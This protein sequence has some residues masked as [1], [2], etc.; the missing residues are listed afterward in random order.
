MTTQRPRLLVIED[1]AAVRTVFAE[2]LPG[3]GYDL[4]LAET[5]EQGFARLSEQ[6]Y[7][8]VLSDIVL[9]GS[10]GLELL[11]RVRAGYPDL[12]VILMTAF[13]SMQS[14]LEAVSAGV[15]DYLVKPFDNLDEVLL[16]IRR[17]IDKRRLVLEN[18]RL[19]EHLREANASIAALNQD[20]EARVERRT[21]ELAAANAQLAE[22]SVTDDVTGLYNQ[23]FL[24]ERLAD[25][26]ARADRYGQPLSVVMLDLDHFKQVNDTRDHLFG[27]RV[28]ARV[29][30]VVRQEV[31][32]VDPVVRYGGDEFVIILPHSRLEQAVS[33][34]ERVR[35]AIAAAN[36]GDSGEVYRIT[37]SFGVAALGACEATDPLALLRAADKALYL[38]KA[39]GRD[40]VAVMSGDR[41][42]AVGA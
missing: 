41:P 20:L 23:R 22:L 19:I 39:L 6:S 2:L 12:D 10:S 31:R 5:A 4:D 8:L 36:L 37:A 21:E 32:S 11:R 17:A 40:R 24:I 18:Q 33:A 26:F 27:S 13:A 7:D 16:T 9:P 25:E 38:A 42:I 35:A 28:L 15:Y 3:A 30:A 34:A 1:D 14:V 29:A